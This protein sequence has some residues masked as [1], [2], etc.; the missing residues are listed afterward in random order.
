MAVCK[1]AGRKLA[2]FWCYSG[3]GKKLRQNF[4]GASQR[5]VCALFCA[6]FA[7]CSPVN[8]LCKLAMTCALW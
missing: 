3:L 4:Q 5:P 2:S 7:S 1:H 6:L 8:L